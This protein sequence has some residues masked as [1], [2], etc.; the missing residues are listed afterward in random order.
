[1]DTEQA[2]KQFQFL[3]RLMYMVLGSSI[4]L[5]VISFGNFVS[6]PNTWP[7]FDNYVGGV[8]TSLQFLALL[9]GIYLLWN[10]PW[11][12][13]PLKTRLNTAFGYFG[14][15]WLCIL[16]LAFIINPMHVPYELNFMIIGSA[17]LIMLGYI[18]TQKRASMLSEDMFP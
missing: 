8:W 6:Y 16:A 9:P 5:V 2:E 14:A 1:M 4:T 15:G 17:I 10:R 12:T 3:N 18:W 13:L 11:N 7:G